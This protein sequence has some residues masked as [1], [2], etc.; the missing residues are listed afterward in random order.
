LQ[1]LGW[2]AYAGLDAVLLLSFSKSSRLRIVALRPRAASPLQIFGCVPMFFYVLH[3]YLIHWLAVL[4]ALL[5][6]QPV[7]WLFHGAIMCI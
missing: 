2:S 1:I 3:L 6:R 7:R 4:V 5:N